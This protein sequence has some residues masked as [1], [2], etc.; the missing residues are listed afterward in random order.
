MRWSGSVK[1]L[2]VEADG[3]S[4]Y[5]QPESGRVRLRT[6]G[7]GPLPLLPGWSPTVL[8][9]GP[10]EVCVLGLR[11]D[12][13]QTAVW[14]MDLAYRFFTN[15]FDELSP[16]AREE[17]QLELRNGAADVWR[18]LIC[19]GRPDLGGAFRQL[20][21]SAGPLIRQMAENVAQQVIP[22]LR[23]VLLD[24]A[25]HLLVIDAVGSGT[26]GK[27]VSTPIVRGLF[28]RQFLLDLIATV[29][30]GRLTL[31]SPIDG[32][33]LSTDIAFVL[34]P[35]TLAY[36]FHDERNDVVFFAFSAHWRSAIDGFYFPSSGLLICESLHTENNLF[37]LA[38]GSPDIALFRHAMEHVLELASYL[39]APV[40]SVAIV[41]IQTHL[42]HHL[43][44]ELGGLDLVVRSIPPDKLPDMLLINARD[45]EMYG[46]IDRIY[47]EFDGKIDRTPRGPFLLARHAYAN[48]L[49]LMRPTDD[50]VP[51]GLAQRIIRHL[52]AEPEVSPHRERHVGLETK[53]FSTVMLG[54]RVENRTLADPVGFFYEAIDT[55]IEQLGKVVIVVD[56]HDAIATSGGARMYE[57]H[58][59][60]VAVRSILDAENDILRAIQDRYARRN[61]IEIVSTVGATMAVTV[62]WCNRACLF[63]TPW[64]AGLAKYRWLCNRPGL[65]VGGHRF[66]L[67]GERLNTH[68]YDAR[69]FMEAPTRV[70][71]FAPDDVEDDP[72]AP[73]L[74]GLNDVHRV[75][76]TVRPGAVR[77]RVLEA[78]ASIQP[79][80]PSTSAERGA[81]PGHRNVGRGRSG[82]LSPAKGQSRD[83]VRQG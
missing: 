59:Q 71:F 3:G 40:R 8:L 47:P 41:Y 29:V 81:D 15:R 46:L 7:D 77:P 27:P 26:E 69:E 65:I 1:I 17:L 49:C 62:F 5:V 37:G 4:F 10:A 38:G 53:G 6:L 44:N 25:D 66:L 58:G 12:N 2:Q 50:Y 14:F 72:D 63:I 52:E 9:Q 16:A 64:G 11:H 19:A 18:Q 76:Y 74:I 80:P 35:G 39:R 79:N 51:R 78:L 82:R 55:L 43:Y 83:A 75:N 34:T 32:A 24:A 68:L 21:G 56:G 70:V 57:S 42:G 31:P 20:F 28:A 13:G 36:K 54:L 23:V 61:D 30:H 48:H 67:R 60:A 22:A 45:S 73:L 33:P